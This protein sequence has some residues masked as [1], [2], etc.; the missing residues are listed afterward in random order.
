VQGHVPLAR[1]NLLSDPRRLVAS[2]TGVGL[3]LMLILL[4]SGLWAGIDAKTTVYE[5][6]SGAAL[7]VAQPG[8]RNFFSTV[9]VIPA[10]T[11]DQVR[12]DPDVEW[13]VPVRGLFSVMQLHDTKIPA[14][15]IGS[16]PGQ[17]GGAW[18]LIKGRTPA[19]DDEIALGQV[20]AARHGVKVGDHLDILGRTFTVVG[21]A[22][23]DMFMTSFVFMTHAAT[24]QILR[25]P[26]TTSFVLVG[27]DQPNQVRAR[28][29]STGL[30]VLDRDQLKRND[31]AVIARPFSLPLRVMVAV[32][33]AV[34]SL[35]IALTAY[36]AIMERRREYGIVKALGATHAR[37]YRLAITQTLTLAV[38][39]L[40]TG[41]VFFLVGRAVISALRPQFLI[42]LTPMV[43]AQAIF[44]ALVMGLVAAI[45][46]SRRLARLD[47]ATAYRG[48]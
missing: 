45:M 33:F 15:L 25:D 46:P 48:G 1:R 14:Y 11:V 41:G 30:A 29:A 35:I 28:L 47:P 40:V 16:E 31:L 17:P 36:S 12:A 42:V 19:G 34:G 26:G 38:I 20:L 21:I 18:H 43:V 10:S 8:T 4:L 13:A 23:A 7:Y 44:A 3:A 39:G 24:D 9:S 6:H 5:D 37:L 22:D 2:A 27:T 32:S